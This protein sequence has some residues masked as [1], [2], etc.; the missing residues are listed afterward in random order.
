ME[1]LIRQHRGRV[2]DSPGDNLLAEFAS[3]VDAV[4][5]AV[6]VQRALTEHNA[7]L[8]AS[9]AMAFRIGINVGDVVLEGDRIYGDG[10]NLAARLEGLAEAGGI[11]ISGTVYEQVDSKLDLPYVY[12]GEQAVKNIAKPVQ[13][14]R[15]AMQPAAAA[16]PVYAGTR[17]KPRPYTRAMLA[18][19]ATLLGLLVGA[20]FWQI[21]DPTAS[22]MLV[23]DASKPSPIPATP[24]I[25][26]LPFDN[27]SG[28]ATQAH[29]SA[30]MTE[31]LITDLSKQAEIAV[32]A[33]H[34]STTVQRIPAQLRR[35]RRELGVCYVLAGSVRTVGDRVRITA[36]LVDTAT[37]HYLWANR[38]DRDLRD[39][40][41]LQEEIAQKIVAALIRTLERPGQARVVDAPRHNVA[42]PTVAMERHP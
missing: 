19:A 29:V 42:A 23:S 2:V 31:D 30:G 11:C 21:G 4:Q 16:L 6:A 41:A 3:V 9:R 26:V 32:M 39:V 38:Y 7:A 25:A 40:F 33:R 27:L 1:R 28:D 35:M 13:V 10:V 24:A 18:T 8:P 37:G 20:I 22:A 5:G 15:I 14:Y 36:Q 12:L 17:A 34:A